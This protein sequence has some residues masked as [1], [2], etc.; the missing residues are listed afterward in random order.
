MAFNFRNLNNI[1]G[2]TGRFNLW[3]YYAT[4]ESG[5]PYTPD[6]FYDAIKFGVK[7]GDV[8]GIYDY[9][10]DTARFRKFRIVDDVVTLEPM[11]LPD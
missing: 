10:D 7:H 6:Y 9:E 3:F 8:I 11:D 4:D 2:S 1:F 5:E